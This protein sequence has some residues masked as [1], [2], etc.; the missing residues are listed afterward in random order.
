LYISLFYCS[1]WSS[2]GGEIA[3]SDGAVCSGGTALTAVRV[4]T[5]RQRRTVPTL[6]VPPTF[7]R[8]GKE[9]F[10]LEMKAKPSYKSVGTNSNKEKA[11][12]ERERERDRKNQYA[13]HS[14]GTPSFWVWKKHTHNTNIT[15]WVWMQFKWM[16]DSCPHITILPSFSH[17]HLPPPHSFHNPNAH[18]SLK[19]NW[20]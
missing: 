2:G 18:R 9:T 4:F 19:Q 1:K 8:W 17:F 12:S 7:I 10:C 6:R 5:Y 14:T 13:K 3:I 16:L 20:N 11:Y 15:S